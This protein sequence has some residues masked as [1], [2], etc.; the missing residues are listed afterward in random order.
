MHIVILFT[1]LE[2][3]SLRIPVIAMVGQK[4]AG[5]VISSA[6]ISFKEYSAVVQCSGSV[7]AVPCGSAAVVQCCNIAVVN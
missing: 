7:L 2:F 4:F 5:H 3:L 6:A 1:R